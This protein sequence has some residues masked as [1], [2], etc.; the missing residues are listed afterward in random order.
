MA[1]LELNPIPNYGQVGP[2]ELSWMLDPRM[3]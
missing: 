3:I 1:C 2:C